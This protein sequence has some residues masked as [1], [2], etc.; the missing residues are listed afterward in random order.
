MEGIFSNTVICAILQELSVVRFHASCT[1]TSGK[2][3][4]GPAP[5]AKSSYSVRHRRFRIVLLQTPLSKR[6]LSRWDLLEN[7]N[8]G[9][10]PSLPLYLLPNF[11][12]GKGCNMARFK[13]HESLLENALW[14]FISRSN[15]G[16][17]TQSV[18]ARLQ[19]PAHHVQTSFSSHRQG[20]RASRAPR[21]AHPPRGRPRTRRSQ[22][23]APSCPRTY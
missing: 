18:Q 23:G 22:C 7:E 21:S 5:P 4:C 12:S 11:K 20:A 10:K 2:P 1:F 14:A 9:L 13:K 15:L 6:P 8:D 19:T 16:L 17:N 3:T